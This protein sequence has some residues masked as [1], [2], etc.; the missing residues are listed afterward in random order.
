MESLILHAKQHNPKSHHE[1]TIFCDVIHNTEKCINSTYV[2]KTGTDIYWQICNYT[3][4]KLV[5]KYLFLLP[6]LWH[7][8]F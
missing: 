8:Y 1:S 4:G 7:F 5:K 6:F 3:I 2:S